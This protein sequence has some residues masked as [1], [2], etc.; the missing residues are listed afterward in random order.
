ME[1][2]VLNYPQRYNIIFS[3]HQESRLL[4]A[5]REPTIEQKEIIETTECPM[6]VIAGPG[7]GKT[8]TLV[9]RIISIIKN[10]KAKPEEILAITF[11]D[12]AAKEL[13]TRISEAMKQ[14]NI[15]NINL[16][17]MYI[18]TFHSFCQR[19]IGENIEKCTDFTRNARL[20]EDTEQFYFFKS[21]IK[22]E[23][24]KSEH[25]KNNITISFAG[26]P[27]SDEIIAEYMDRF[28]PGPFQAA[29]AVCT[30]CDKLIEELVD[31]E[32]MK[33]SDNKSV[34]T[35][36]LMLEEYRRILTENDL[37]TFSTLLEQGYKLLLNDPEDGKL[38]NKFKYIMVDEF[39][40]T[41]H[42]QEKLVDM[43]G[44]KN[45]YICVVGDDDQSLYRFRGAT[46]ENILKFSDK[47]KDYGCVTK[48]LSE[49]FRSTGEIVGFY[50]KWMDD[51]EYFDWGRCRLPKNL[52]TH[53]TADTPTV[54]KIT[55][56]T[57]Y[58]W[59]ISVFNFI[60]HLKNSGKITDFN[61]I[62]F[63][64]KSVKNKDVI[65]LQNILTKNGIPVYSPRSKR[66]FYRP[67]VL[68]AIGCMLY[69]LSINGND[70]YIYK[71]KNS[72]QII[73]HKSPGLSRFV[74]RSA[75]TADLKIGYCEL[76]YRLFAFEPFKSIIDTDITQTYDKLR[77]VR[78]LAQL[79]QIIS[80]FEKQN[81]SRGKKSHAYFVDYLLT[82]I[83]GG[84]DEYESPKE[85]APSGY[86][87]FMTFHQSKGLEF[88][89]VICDS[90]RNFPRTNQGLSIIDTILLSQGRQFFE[91]LPDRGYF[92][93]YR[94]YYTA[95]SRA[96][97]L[98]VLTCYDK[99]NYVFSGLLDTVPNA[100]RTTPDLSKLSFDAVESADISDSYSFTS[101]IL[102]YEACPKKYKLAKKL[103]FES[104]R[105][106]NE[107][108][109]FGTLVHQTIE[110]IHKCARNGGTPDEESINTWLES[111]SKSLSNARGVDLSKSLSVAKEQVM[112]YYNY[113]LS[114]Y[115]KNN[116][117]YVW[118][119][120]TGAEK[121]VSLLMKADD[122]GFIM[123]GT[124]DMVREYPKYY[125]IFDIKSGKKSDELIEGYNR[126]LRVYAH[127]LSKI[128]QSREMSMRLFF[129]GE[130]EKPQSIIKYEDEKDN[131]DKEIEHFSSV[132]S[133]I[134]NNKFEKEADKDLTCRECDFRF[135]CGKAAP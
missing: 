131:I 38:R 89:V 77:P 49:N 87:S 23:I 39:Q 12:K 13:I 31:I 111:N 1:I 11:T 50:T 68:Q 20:L 108:A 113:V 25:G 29:K 115:G 70:K 85:S 124:L 14:E 79:T 97:A 37:M 120:I 71:A 55:K 5:K 42:I 121:N 116:P 33:K 45:K 60:I 127:M 44:G 62:A 135:F 26:I 22:P 6:L 46:V 73:I 104:A 21:F 32:K 27:G 16:D 17:D 91:P 128:A 101:D 98:L 90:L 82:K 130:D 53:K 36:G 93:F 74:N 30:V 24:L 40:D 105:K 133:L 75:R 3:V 86:I 95:F 119:N 72:A 103:E 56:S 57:Q 66:F 96:K 67:E 83:Y 78:N 132:V 35:A 18:S 47:Y 92:D 109:L 41:N 34:R 118:H 100:S 7:T 112:N 59:C 61:Q 51:P 63:L 126:Q 117:E 106:V 88:P 99:P 114:H 134:M 19:L 76:L 64:C 28:N 125:A 15:N 110:D 58:Q 107:G 129:T 94:E 54:V 48:H 4:M 69:A 52:M 80:V 9:N 122:K 2:P 8:F 43:L 102:L 84:I 10:K 65:A 81:Q 123:K